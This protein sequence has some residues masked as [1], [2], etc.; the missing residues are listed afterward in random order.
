MKKHM[1]RLAAPRT[2]KIERKVKIWTAKPSPGSHPVDRSVPIVSLLRTY[3]NYS[4]NWREASAILNTRTVKIDGK[5]V[6]RPK[7]PV[8]LMDVVSID[9]TKENHRMLL[10]K[11][12]RLHLVR[13]MENEAKWKLVRIEDKHTVPGGMTQLNLH[14]GRNILLKKSQYSTRTTLKIQLPDQKIL[15]AYPLEKDN[16]VLLIGGRHAGE[17]VHVDRLELTRNPRANLVH[18]KEGFS[19]IID[20]AFVIGAE[21]A[22]ITLPEGAAL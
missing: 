21:R 4:D 22:E 5:V 8:G 12:G 20:H 1:K 9:E 16:T 13:I 18:F 7:F 10:D 6:T 11:K 2:W 15:G 17:V 14:D 19:T 3:L